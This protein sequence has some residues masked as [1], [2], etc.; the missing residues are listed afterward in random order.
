MPAT[1]KQKLAAHSLDPSFFFH[2]SWY[3]RVEVDA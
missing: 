2:F 1:T 3:V